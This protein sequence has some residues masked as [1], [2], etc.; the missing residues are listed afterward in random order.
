MPA[1]MPELKINKMLPELA[2]MLDSGFYNKDLL[3]EYKNDIETLNTIGLAS[4]KN[5]NALAVIACLEG[6]VE[7]MRSYFREIFKYSGETYINLMNYSMVLM[8]SR[9]YEE[10]F[11]NDR[12][13][14]GIDDSAEILLNRIVTIS[15]FLNKKNEFNRYTELYKEKFG[16]EHYIKTSVSIQRGNCGLPDTY[17]DQFNKAYETIDKHAPGLAEF[18]DYPIVIILE[19]CPQMG[20]LDEQWKAAIIS[21]ED[22]DT[23]LDRMDKFHDWCIDEDM[24]KDPGNFFFGIDVMEEG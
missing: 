6:E 10:A 14:F 20:G 16:K 22:I 13:A 3:M 12:K 18:F 4:E 7:L 19:L 21:G 11:A 23:G 9:R 8:H 15:Y 24:K 1:L 17:R 2:S 5:Y